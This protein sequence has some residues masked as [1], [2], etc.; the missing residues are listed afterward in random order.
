MR[1]LGSHNILQQLP[2]LL[3]PELLYNNN[4]NVYLVFAI[5]RLNKMYEKIKYFM[6]S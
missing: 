2:P 4:N 1:L 3:V 5:I 6:H